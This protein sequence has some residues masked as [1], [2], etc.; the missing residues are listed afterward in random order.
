M[1]IE[2]LIKRKDEYMIYGIGG[3]GEVFL[4]FLAALSFLSL[5]FFI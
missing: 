5:T 1:F 2:K 4:L 3:K